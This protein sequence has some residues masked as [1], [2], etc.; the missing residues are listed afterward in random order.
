MGSGKWYRTVEDVG[1]QRT[2]GAPFVCSNTQ[3]QHS[4]MCLQGFNHMTPWILFSSG[5]RCSNNDSINVRRALNILIRGR[6]D[7][8]WKTKVLRSYNGFAAWLPDCIVCNLNISGQQPIFDERTFRLVW[9][10]NHFSNN[11]A[12]HIKPLS[13]SPSDPCPLLHIFV[14]FE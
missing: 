3:R 9:F 2:R 8:L 6:V 4:P 1:V 5:N 11:P 7:R 10:L 13:C 12:A 14:L